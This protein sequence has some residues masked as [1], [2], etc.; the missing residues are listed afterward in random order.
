MLIGAH[1]QHLNIL[2]MHTIQTTTFHVFKMY[3][4]VSQYTV[5]RL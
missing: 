2:K 1:C 5:F 3:K 4:F